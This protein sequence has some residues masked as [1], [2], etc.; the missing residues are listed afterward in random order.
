MKPYISKK[1]VMKMSNFMMNNSM[2]KKAKYV[3][4]GNSTAAIAAIES[5]RAIDYSG[6]IILIS[7]EPYHTYSRPLISY[8]IEGKVAEN[9]I[10]YRAGDFY[11]TNGVDTILRQKAAGLDTDIREVILE[12]STRIKYDRLLIA[13]GSKPLIPPCSGLDKNNVFNFIKFDDAKDI[14]KY[15]AEGS[16]AVVIGA[17]FS[18]LKA[19]EALVRKGVRVTAVDIAPRLMPRLLDHQASRMIEGLLERQGVGLLLNTTVKSVAGETADTVILESGEKLPCDFVIVTAGVKSNTDLLNTSGV[20]LNRGVIVDEMMMTNMP[21]VYAAGDVAEYH[22][23][24][25]DTWTVAATLPSAYAQG[26]AAGANMAGAAK[27][28]EA[29]P[30]F[31]SMPILGTVIMGAGASVHT[32]GLEVVTRQ[33]PGTDDSCAKFVISGNRLTGYLF[34]NDISRPGIYTDLIKSRTDITPFKDSLGSED[35][36]F[37]SMPESVRQRM[38]YAGVET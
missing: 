11:K 25:T 32:P 38:L 37:L 6:S 1:L 33:R 19:V 36:G 24:F 31:N 26:R 8:Y 18:G 3:I 14:G 12:D 28:Y 7:D 21:G 34:I 4:I 17:S 2:N 22:D 20:K 10:R 5:I 15:A 27:P 16:R 35:F 13:T 9:G 29:Q 23:P 30:I